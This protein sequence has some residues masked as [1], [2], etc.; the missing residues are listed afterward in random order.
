MTKEQ[1]LA[2]KKN[3]LLVL[4]NNGKNSANSGVIKRLNREI[5][6]LKAE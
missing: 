2:I 6:K 3:R 5:R 1:T 4:M